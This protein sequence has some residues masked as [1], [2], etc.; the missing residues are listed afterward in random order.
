VL[1]ELAGRAS[2][3]ETVSRG[4]HARVD[5]LQG[6]LDSRQEER[7][8][9]E[10]RAA[11]GEYSTAQWEE[12]RGVADSEIDQ[13]SA[14]LA[15]QRSELDRVEEILAIARSPR[16]PA[17][18][19]TN[20]VPEAPGAAPVAAPVTAPVAVQPAE[21][22]TAIKVVR[23]S[24]GTPT[25]GSGRVTPLHGTDRVTPAYGADALTFTPGREDEAVAAR[26]EAAAESGFDDLAF[27]KSIVEPTAQTREPAAPAPAAAPAPGA[28]STRPIPRGE[29]SRLS[30]P[31]RGLAALRSLLGAD[32]RSHTPAGRNAVPQSAQGDETRSADEGTTGTG[33]KTLRCGECG[34]LNYPTEWYCERCGGALAAM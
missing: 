22:A 3:L 13:V 28:S 27:L 18:D 6:E 10:V 4:L 25:Q 12:L 16:G 17:V 32:D 21:E 23:A 1:A 14:Q 31:G 11:V 15:E 26:G 5:T 33:A 34:T 30:T 2:E 8:E 9:A 20:A 19:A 29:E 7:A 24:D